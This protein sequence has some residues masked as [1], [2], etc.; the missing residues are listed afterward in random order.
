MQILIYLVC[1]PLLLIVP[2]GIETDL[3]G[4]INYNYILLIV[5]YG[6][7]TALCGSWSYILPLL[8]VPYGIETIL[9]YV[10]DLSLFLF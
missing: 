8:I 3:C 10:Y 9:L 6:I 1:V 5:P 2:Y 4:D 7:E